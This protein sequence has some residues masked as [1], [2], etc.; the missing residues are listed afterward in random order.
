[1]DSIQTS[2]H[3]TE[4][5]SRG[6]SLNSEVVKGRGS[7]SYCGANS[8]T[9]MNICDAFCTTLKAQINIKKQGLQNKLMLK[10]P[11]GENEKESECSLFR[12]RKDPF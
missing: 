2:L 1:M 12:L 10:Q 8:Y 7:Q 3:G 9:E 4:P 5:N 11:F 6:G